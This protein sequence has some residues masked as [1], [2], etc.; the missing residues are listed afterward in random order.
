[1]TSIQQFDYSVDLSQSIIW[2]RD[3]A[4][5]LLSLIEAKQSWYDG[6]QR[7]FWDN[8]YHDV[9]DLRTAN[10][11]GLT[12]WAIIL[13]LP[14]VVSTPAGA[15]RPVIGFGNNYRNFLDPSNFADDNSALELTTEEKRLVLRLRYFQLVSDGCPESINEA[16]ALLFGDQGPAYVL[17]GLDMT[18][19][20]VFLFLPSPRVLAVLSAFD[21]LPRPAG[22]KLRVLIDPQNVFGFGPFYLNFRNSNFGGG[23]A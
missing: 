22:V 8:W 9:F 15:N 4:A 3:N 5:R 11:F 21:I 19:E 2:Q 20:Y 13:G 7:D 18:C 23:T 14:L 12:V 16:L 1:M 6:N 10:D 17:D